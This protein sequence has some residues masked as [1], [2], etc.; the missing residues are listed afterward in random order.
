MTSN[1]F[2]FSHFVTFKGMFLELFEEN[3]EVEMGGYKAIETHLFET[4][5]ASVQ[6][7]FKLNKMLP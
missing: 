1:A 6:S 7:G 3:K 5:G 4:Y 2:V